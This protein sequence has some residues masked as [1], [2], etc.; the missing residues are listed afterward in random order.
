MHKLIRNIIISVVVSL[1]GMLCLT[2]TAFPATVV[3]VDR[4]IH[5]GFELLIIHSDSM[6][7]F[8]LEYNRV[9]GVAEL[10]LN[11]GIIN[12]R[13]ANTLTRMVA[14]LT[15]RGATVDAA[16]GI[17]RFRTPHPV[18]IREYLVSGPPALILDF[19][20]VDSGENRLP[21]ELDRE[22]YLKL[23]SAAE[24]SGRLEQALDYVEHVRKWEDSD[25]A[26]THKA[27]VIEQR[28]GR[29]DRALETLA[30]SA[31]IAE[32]AAD[33]HAR[34]TM[35]FLAKGD[36]VSMG[37]E[38]AGYFHRDS[39]KS[40]PA[41]V[42]PV[43]DTMTLVQQ[44]EPGT[45]QNPPKK[46]LLK[47]PIVL[48]AGGGNSID[49]LYY[50]WGFLIVGFISLI[51]L[52][53]GARKSAFPKGYYG[54]V[55]VKIPPGKD[56]DSHMRSGMSERDLQSIP[57]SREYPEPLSSITP[58]RTTINLPVEQLSP[59]R[60]NAEPLKS[61]PPPP[62]TNYRSE[63]ASTAKGRVPVDEIIALAE[64][65]IKTDEIAYKLMVG[66]DEV[67]MVLNL[68]RLA[69]RQ[70]SAAAQGRSQVG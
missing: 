67:A 35:I 20:L 55:D 31:Q 23:G 57:R 53:L 56:D 29:W 48:S 5:D 4:A 28:L 50:G 2:P 6:P 24:H 16:K 59:P 38:W 54:S 40:Q 7:D 25:I 46:N 15:I 39:K 49:Y 58:N 62:R 17:I 21:F 30:E 26:L 42:E 3:R 32:F 9:A 51:G 8:S 1:I 37:N 44:D 18:H 10:K 52:L 33:A 45:P 11:R 43:V 66:R 63:S 68:A 14:G 22:K 27:G 34:R 65:G 41:V 70:S 64:N 12:R 47:F 61:T 36:T 19:S 60:I 69:R 13:A